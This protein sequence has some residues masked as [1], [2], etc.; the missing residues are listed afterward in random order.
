[1]NQKEFNEEKKKLR[2][3]Y[4]LLKAGLE[5]WDSIP[6]HFQKL[7]IKYYGIVVI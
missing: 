6:A 4:K 2:M 1:M 3:H 5:E 7:L